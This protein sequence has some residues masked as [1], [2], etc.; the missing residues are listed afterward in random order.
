M[1]YKKGYTHE[2]LNS[3]GSKLNEL[4]LKKYT[5]NNAPFT[6]DKDYG[7]PDIATLGFMFS[8]FIRHKKEYK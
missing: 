8:I 5:V 3:V 2:F 6:E 7:R 1:N 4:I